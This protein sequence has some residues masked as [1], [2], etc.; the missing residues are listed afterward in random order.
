ME[1]RVLHV[2]EEEGSQAPHTMRCTHPSTCTIHDGD[3][4]AVSLPDVE[5]L[6]V[7]RRRAGAPR[8]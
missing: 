2:K 1:R 5:G 8:G 3:S 4:A 7:A 6:H